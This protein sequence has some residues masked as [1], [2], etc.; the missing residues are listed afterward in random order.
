MSDVLLI[1]SHDN[2]GDDTELRVIMLANDGDMGGDVSD[3]DGA[4]VDGNDNG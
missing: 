2:V 3:D 1:D 4:G